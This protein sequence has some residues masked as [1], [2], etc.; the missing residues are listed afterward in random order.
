MSDII[1]SKLGKR[2][3][4]MVGVF[5]YAQLAEKLVK[6]K[7][8]FRAKGHRKYLDRAVPVPKVRREPTMIGRTAEPNPPTY[9]DLLTDYAEGEERDREEERR[10]RAQKEYED[11]R[12][13][14]LQDKNDFRAENK[15]YED[16]RDELEEFCSK[17]DQLVGELECGFEDHKWKAV[18]THADF[19][20]NPYL[21]KAFDVL[22][23]LYLDD[24]NTGK[25]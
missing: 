6:W 20:A 10:S 8:Y 12:K 23:S 11:Q 25:L 14:Y 9:N 4:K 2:P 1:E 21:W 24:D 13:L 15:L 3:S 19:I 5:A 22:E 17:H 7:E 16:E 18:K